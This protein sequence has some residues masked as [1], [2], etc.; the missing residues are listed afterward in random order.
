MTKDILLVGSARVKITPK[1][2][3]TLSGYYNVRVSEGVLDDLYLN[4]V[5]FKQGVKKYCV[6]SADL[7]GIQAELILRFKKSPKTGT[8][9]M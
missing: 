9:N 2:G 3:I 4:A 6:I 8:A 1:I 7:A 5:A